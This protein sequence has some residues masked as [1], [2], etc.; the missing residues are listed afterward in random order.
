[1]E[2][3]THL[4]IRRLF[5]HNIFDYR[6]PGQSI[7]GEDLFHEKTWSL[8]GLSPYQIAAAGA[9]AGTGIGLGIDAATAGIS[10]G[11]FAVSGAILGAGS[12]LVGGKRM[13]DTEIKGPKV[14][15][16]QMK[17]SLGGFM[18]IVGPNRNIQFP[19]I[20]LDRALIYFSHAIN[21]AHGRRNRQEETSD[22]NPETFVA[23]FTDHQRRTCRKFFQ[24]VSTG[25][26]ARIR[27]AMQPVLDMLLET[28]TG[29]SAREYR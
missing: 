2:R 29:L 16:F 21:W 27:E 26:E 28:L 19:F 3:K 10:F 12:A 14:G 25:D 23:H 24:A 15:R 5:K 13:V 9:A 1:V 6:L 17:K 8:L 18:L 11:V 7:A 4:E 22:T 20:L